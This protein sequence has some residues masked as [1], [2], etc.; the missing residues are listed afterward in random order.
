MITVA[1]DIRAGHKTSKE[2][3]QHLGDAA[4]EESA[5]DHAQVF[6]ESKEDNDQPKK[7]PRGM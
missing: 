3:R 1:K 6:D 5:K 7:A 4:K 2:S